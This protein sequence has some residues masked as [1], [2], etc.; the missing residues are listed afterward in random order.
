MYLFTITS[1]LLL[2]VQIWASN[3]IHKEERSCVGKWDIQSLTEASSEFYGPEQY[4]EEDK[5]PR[6]LKFSFRN[7]VRCRIVWMTL[8]FQR[9]GSSSVN[10]GQDFNLLSLDENPFSEPSRRAS[11]GGPVQ[12]DPCLHAK[13]IL[14]FGSPVKKDVGMTSSQGS[15]QITVRSWLDKPPPLSRFKVQLVLPIISLIWCLLL[16]MSSV[17]SLII[18]SLFQVPIEAERLADN[19]LVVEHFLSPASPMLSGFRIDGFSAIKPRVIHAPFCETKMWDTSS[20]LEDR[21]ISPAVLYIQV[22]ALK[23][24]INI[25]TS[26][27]L[28]IN[29]LSCR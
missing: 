1:L 29:L 16:N 7:P 13:R 15:D 4:D 22:S 27:L 20:F 21:L 6:H 3:K 12:S 23:V 14:V 17:T 18:F 5:A 2:Q 24:F 19:D 9:L 25:G 10:F 11:L 28:L 26:V 8:S